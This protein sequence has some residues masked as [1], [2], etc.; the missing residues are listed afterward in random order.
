[1][2]KG[3]ELCSHVNAVA[4]LDSQS[5]FAPAQPKPVS[6]SSQLADPPLVSALCSCT[7]SA[8]FG[9][10]TMCSI[11]LAGQL[12]QDSE[13]NDIH[14][15]QLATEL[16]LSS[17]FY[18]PVGPCMCTNVPILPAVLYTH[19]ESTTADSKYRC[20]Q[21]TI[22]SPASR[23]EWQQCCHANWAVPFAGLRAGTRALGKVE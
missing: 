7:F 13:S 15:S 12:L 5:G 17:K 20:L 2:R 18:T 6:R 9:N 11:C 10:A 8:V 4:S 16:Q 22:S 21:C 1:M 23:S 14:P 3:R 19:G